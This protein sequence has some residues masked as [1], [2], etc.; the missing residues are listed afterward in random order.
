MGRIQEEQIWG[1]N[2]EFWDALFETLNKQAEILSQ[3]LD[4]GVWSSQGEEVCPGGVNLGGSCIFIFLPCLK[5][6]AV[7]LPIITPLIQNFHCYLH[8]FNPNNL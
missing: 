4:T 7:I 8:F 1:E 5:S 6:L 3:Y 2:Q